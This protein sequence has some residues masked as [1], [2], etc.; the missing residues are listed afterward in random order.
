MK[1]PAIKVTGFFIAL[2]FAY[3]EESIGLQK[4]YHYI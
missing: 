2:I 3:Y 4:I 1:N